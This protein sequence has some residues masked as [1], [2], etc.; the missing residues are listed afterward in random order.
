MTKT[1]IAELREILDSRKTWIMPIS[2]L[3][4]TIEECLDEI[5]RLQATQERYRQIVEIY[6]GWVNGTAGMRAAKWA[7]QAI[8]KLIPETP[9]K[10]VERRRKSQGASR[11]PAC[12]LCGIERGIAGMECGGECEVKANAR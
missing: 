5:E 10:S 7:M 1:R 6:N 11:A 4:N 12:T 8:G 2:K 9:S 3:E